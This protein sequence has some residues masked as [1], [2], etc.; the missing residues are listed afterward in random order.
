MGPSGIGLS[1][2]NSCLQ[3]AEEMHH[4][5]TPETQ[6][7]WEKSKQ[8][9]AA[10]HHQWEAGYAPTLSPNFLG[11][12][13]QW[14]TLQAPPHSDSGVRSLI[15][16]GKRKWFFCL[17]HSKSQVRRNTGQKEFNRLPALCSKLPAL[18][19]KLNRQEKRTPRQLAAMASEWV[20][21]V[22]QLYLMRIPK[23]IKPAQMHDKDPANP[24]HMTVTVTL[25]LLA[26][27]FTNCILRGF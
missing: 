22:A 9:R 21:Q 14:Q 3:Q 6:T 20:S 11:S 18:C 24:S 26:L 2:G 17:S 1:T 5:E 7:P 27:I 23:V 25:S 13:K 12:M 15:F 4:Q 16:I 8:Q 10:E 19:S